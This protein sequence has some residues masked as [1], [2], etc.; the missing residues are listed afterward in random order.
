MSIEFQ[1]LRARFE[2]LLNQ[3]APPEGLFAQ[4]T[5]I[6][7]QWVEDHVLEIINW[8]KAG[9]FN[10]TM[11]QWFHWYLPPDGNHWNHL[12]EEAERLAKA[13]ITAVWL[14]PVYKGHGGGYDVGYGV[15]DLVDLGEFDQ[16]GSIRTKYG[17]KDQLV[18]ATEEAKRHGLQI[19]VD[20]VF[21][22]KMG[23]DEPEEVE[24]FPVD[25]DDRNKIIGEA[26]NIQAWTHF[27]FPGR[28]GKYSSLEWHWWHFDAVDYDGYSG[29][30]QIYLFKDKQFDSFVELEKGNYDYLMGCDLDME[31][32]EVRGELKYWSEWFM[33]TIGADGFRFDAIKHISSWFF[34]DWLDHVQNYAERDLFALGEYW[35]PNLDVLSWYIGESGGQMRLFDV[36]LHYNFSV[37]G[38]VGQDYDMRGILDNTLMKHL[39]LFAVTF[40]DNHDSQP[41]QSLESVVESW[42]KPLAYAV[43]LLREQGYPCI[44]YA[45]Y[46]GANYRDKGPD[47]NEYEIWM[48]SHQWIIDRLLF[49]RKH[50]A[51]GDQ[52][53]Y[54][55]HPNTIGWT[56]LGNENHPRAMAVIMSNGE[57]GYKWMEVGK[58]NAIFYD[59]TEHIKDPIQTNEDGWAEFRCNGGSVSVWLEKQTLMTQ[60]SD[61]IGSLNINFAPT[62][63]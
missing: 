25:W 54:F 48:D 38:K 36:P 22:H 19:Y 3:D 18:A 39:P 43:I 31:S 28:D 16:N 15:Y 17:K 4:G 32:E 14:P 35:S 49:A 41:L 58:P 20:V 24:A 59:I 63:D 26:R 8:S 1:S 12:R 57:E 40:V 42:F 47:G 23:G 33:D 45:D 6:L 53:D 11:M 61:F 10:G 55:D 9:E 52:Y 29:D 37:A 34:N 30:T 50:Y 2:T 7:Q 62:D 13:G 51:Y 21:N 27:T 60:F 56:R 44:F 5:R 46:Y